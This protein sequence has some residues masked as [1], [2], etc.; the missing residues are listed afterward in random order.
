MKSGGAGVKMVL[1]FLRKE[2]YN[3]K[4]CRHKRGQKKICSH[5]CGEEKG[6]KN[7]KN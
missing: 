5:F 2:W 7:G 1:E 6:K 4:D 3:S